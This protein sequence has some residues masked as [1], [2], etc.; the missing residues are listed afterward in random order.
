MAITETSQFTKEKKKPAYKPVVFIN[1]PGPVEYW[2]SRFI[3][4]S[5]DTSDP[6]NWSNG[7]ADYEDQL[8][9]I[10]SI[11]I[12][13]NRFGGVATIGNTNIDIINLGDYSDFLNTYPTIEGDAVTIYIIFDD[14]TA[15][16]FNESV[17]VFTGIVDDYKVSYDRITVSI[18][19]AGLFD[20][21]LIGTLFDSS[22]AVDSNFGLPSMTQGKIRQIVYGPHVNNKNTFSNTTI[23][24]SEARRLVKLRYL[25]NLGNEYYFQVADH[26]VTLD[27]GTWS[28]GTLGAGGSVRAGTLWAEKGNNFYQINMTYATGGTF[29]V[30]S[31][32]DTDGCV[33]KIDHDKTA[34]VNVRLVDYLHPDGTANE[35]NVGA[36]DW[37][38]D[39]NTFDRDKVLFSDSA[40][41]AGGTPV[42]DKSD[43]DLT[44]PDWAHDNLSDSD[45]GRVLVIAKT[46]Y[47]GSNDTFTIHGGDATANGTTADFY[48]VQ[49]LTGTQAN[50]SAN[51]NLLHQVTGAGGRTVRIY[52]V[53]KAIEFN[54]DGTYADYSDSMFIEVTDGKEYGSWISTRSNHADYNGGSGAGDPI[55]N[56]AGVIEDVLRTYLSLGD[57]DINTASFDTASN[58]RSSWE[59][60][61]EIYEQTDAI[62]LLNNLAFESLMMIW[63]DENNDVK[64]RAILAA[65][66]ETFTN[67][68]DD[69]YPNLDDIISD[70]PKNNYRIIAGENDKLDWKEGVTTIA[71]TLTPGDYTDSGMAF[72]IQTQMNNDAP[73]NTYTVAGS[74]ITGKFTINRFAGAATFE[75]LTNTGTN[76]GGDSAWIYLGFNTLADKTGATSYV[77]DDAV[78]DDSF[79]EHFCIDL[80]SAAKTKFSQLTNDLFVNYGLTWQDGIYQKSST[81]TDATSQTNYGT[82][83][84]TINILR[85]FDSTTLTTWKTLFFNLSKDRFYEIPA[86]C[87]LDVSSVE[88][89]DIYNIQS[90]ITK[91]LFGDANYRA[92]KYQVISKTMSLIRNIGLVRLR[93]IERE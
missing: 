36:G 6:V 27:T 19:Y 67:S 64:T 77:S 47:V 76:V 17:K 26:A 55:T 20:N 1:F 86:N 83:S 23:D 87:C 13:I 7:T 38:N 80:G 22:D 56:P 5:A 57:S 65:S 90:N 74:S 2:A 82:K 79:A 84:M 43:I 35:N 8:S 81:S 91:S 73:A 49:S 71:S 10:G 75:L 40:I 92:K 63:Y 50:V 3:D 33:I 11:D 70:S 39:D 44:Y 14:G 54:G 41:T 37:N 59:L 61:F 12:S 88:I 89:G 32:N 66:S 46:Y 93:L 53:F 21:K 15:L 52:E 48:V 30:V 42:G 16:T 60:S 85:I 28:S 31:N 58:D 24:L 45:V 68:G 18:S 72:E 34:A 9:S 4:I 25:G 62:Q 69:D 51:S 29:S 78:F